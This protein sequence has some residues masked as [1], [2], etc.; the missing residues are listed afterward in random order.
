MKNVILGVIVLTAALA[1]AQGEA[2]RKPVVL[3]VAL[4][5]VIDECDEA[6]DVIGALSQKEAEKGK[7]ISAKTKDL[8]ARKKDLL[9]K[10]LSDR[11]QKW[12]DEFASV[13]K[14]DS[15]IKSEAAHFEVTTADEKA[16][17]LNAIL[18]EARGVAERIRSERGADVVL[19]SKMSALGFE[20]SKELQE[21][22]LFRR[23]LAA[24][25]GADITKDILEALNASYKARKK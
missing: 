1:I 21:E 4:Q 14:A 10:K 2:S 11:D 16:R 15:E 9:G 19:V 5:A 25:P 23:V 12:Y 17:L 18:R 7:A 22:Y 6:K 20:D 24:A 8:E 13:A 3:V